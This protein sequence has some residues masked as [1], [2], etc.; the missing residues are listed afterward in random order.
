MFLKNV[1]RGTILCE[2]EFCEEVSMFHV[3]QFGGIVCLTKIMQ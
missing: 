3:E 2:V 1:P